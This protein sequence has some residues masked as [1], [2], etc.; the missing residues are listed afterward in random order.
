LKEVLTMAVADTQA[1][2]RLVHSHAG[3]WHVDPRRIGL[4]GFSAGG[5]VAVATALAP[6]SD[7]SPD[8]LVSLYGPSLTDVHVRKDSPP[9]FIAVGSE[10]F[11]V[12]S[13]CLALFDAWRSA[14]RPAE[15]HLYDNV[16]GGFGM[17]TRG[18][19]VDGWK[20]R[21]VEWLAAR[22]VLDDPQAR[23]R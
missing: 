2:V 13:G 20:D 15:L 8:F 3:E 21:L 5:G 22:G 23:L 11:N 14:G 10:H 6:S 1:A 17:S 19:P 4:M 16:S 9:L 12:T 18:L 7:S